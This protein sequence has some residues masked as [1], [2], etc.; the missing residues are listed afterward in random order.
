[1][2]IED[3]YAPLF[4]PFA[5]AHCDTMNGPIIPEARAALEKG[6]VTPILQ[7]VKKDD[8]GEIRAAFTQAVS[9][10]GL[11]SQAK[12][13]AD[14]YFLETLIRLHRA[15]EGAP[16]TGLKD[17]PIDPIVA[18]ADKALVDGSSDEMIN[19]LNAHMAKAILEKFDKAL[20]TR[21]DRFNSVD[22]GREYVEAYV[23][24]VHYIEGIHNAILSTAG[25]EH[26]GAA[27]SIPHK[28]AKHDVH[29]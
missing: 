23:T 27:E 3:T 21:R 1:M 10:R 4:L 5:S 6:D 9:V 24:Y 15:G 25:H 8:E 18:M 20:S 12:E 11:G 13:L 17:E 28:S 16:Y 22:A 29:E 2:F 19:K 7:W 26:I 14:R